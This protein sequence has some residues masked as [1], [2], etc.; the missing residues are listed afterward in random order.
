MTP[1]AIRIQPRLHQQLTQNN[2]PFAILYD[3]D[4]D[5]EHNANDD[6]TVVASNCSQKPPWTDP[7][8]LMTQANLPEPRPPLISRCPRPPVNPPPAPLHTI[9]M[10]VIQHNHLHLRVQ[11]AIPPRS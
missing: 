7:P 5:D 11:L 2:N 6:A 8:R 3:E 10:D 4:D 9:P 1:P